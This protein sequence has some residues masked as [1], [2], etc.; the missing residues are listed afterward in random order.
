[1]LTGYDE[2]PS[3]A[4]LGYGLSLQSGGPDLA[5]PDYV[6]T[7]LEITDFTPPEDEVDDVEVTNH[8]SPDATKEYI[9]GLSDAGEVSFTI[10]YVPRHSVG[11]DTP[12]GRLFESKRK[13]ENEAWRIRYSDGTFEEFRAYVKGISRS[14]PVDDKMTA[15]VTM[16]V[17]GTSRF[18]A[19][20]DGDGGGN[21]G[22]GGEGGEGPGTPPAGYT[23]DTGAET[24]GYEAA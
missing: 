10:N 12:I 14:I 24:S 23:A 7:G 5:S 21:G 13:R 3:E 1:M 4:E 22:N 18:S 11:T 6:D 15:D 8:R 9:S 17:S 20:E 16:K 2:H 19:G